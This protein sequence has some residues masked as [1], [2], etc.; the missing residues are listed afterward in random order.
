MAIFRNFA[1]MIRATIRPLNTDIHISIPSEYVGKNIEVL[2]Y[3]TDEATNIIPEENTMARFKGIL[4]PE[5]AEHLQ[6]YVKKS[7]EEWSKNI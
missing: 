1:H 2:L 6:E 7:R 5:E 4:T 3:A